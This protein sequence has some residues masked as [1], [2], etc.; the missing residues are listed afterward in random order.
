MRTTR[1]RRLWDLE[2][3]EERSLLSTAGGKVASNVVYTTLGGPQ[4]LDVYAPNGVAPARGWPVVLAIHG[5]GWR[6]FDKSQYA[7]KVAGPLVRD[8]Y[9][10][11]APDYLLSA[12]RA[13]SWPTNFKQIQQAA[14]WV[15]ASSAA[16]HFD[17]SRIAAMGESAGGHLAA[18]LGTDS[19]GAPVRSVID[20]F[21]PTDL[22]TLAAQ[23]P[24]ARPA[25]VQFLG[26]Q[27]E[28]APAL[29]AAASPVD[30]VAPGDPP[31][32]I[33]QGS[34]DA[35]VPAVQSRELA[36]ALDTAGVP[37]QLQIIAGAGHGFGIDMVLA[38]VTGFLRQ[39]L[40]G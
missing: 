39:T 29:Y 30:H 7:R 34:A 18:L 27:P 12:P 6:R 25:V 19:P 2:R 1:P 40:G 5:G 20:F 32:L 8:G 4:T 37:N 36:A 11:V 33:L 9:A 10:V 17:S 22:G 3:L 13:P 31:M 26:A 35:I 28:Q 14:N 21:G 16:Y 38:E 23:S 24:L 15:R